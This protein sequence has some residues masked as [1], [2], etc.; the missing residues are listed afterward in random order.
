MFFLAAALLACPAFAQRTTNP[1][2]TTGAIGN[3]GTLVV[4]VR[5]QNGNIPSGLTLVN[6]YSF[7]GDLV[8]SA[9]MQGTQA[10]FQGIGTGRFS[11]EAIAPGYKTNRVDV[12]VDFIGS[13]VTVEIALKPEVDPNAPSAAPAAPLL[14]PRAQKELNKA[15]EDL[16]DGKLK[17]AQRHLDA[18][19]HM[20]PG[21]PD[22]NYLLGVLASM[23]GKRD[24][25]V[26]LWQ[27][28]IDIYPQHTFALL[29]LG[30]AAEEK[31]DLTAAS[32]FFK[33][34]ADSN[35]SSWRSQFSLAGIAYREEKY[36]DAVKYSE[37]ALRIGKDKANEARF[38]QARALALL[39]HRD[40]AVAALQAY[41][42]QASEKPKFA[43][44][45]S[46]ILAELQ[47]AASE[48]PRRSAP[49]KTTTPPA[50][51]AAVPVALL[52]NPSEWLPPDVDAAVPPTT[53]DVACP[54]GDVL[55]GAGKRM[56]EFLHA[57]DRFTATEHLHHED[58]GESGLPSG[59]ADRT[60]Y[61][62]VSI[63]EVRPR[64][65]NVE[66]YR[67]GSLSSE[68]F[69]NHIATRGF[70]SL[71]LVF[72]PYYRDNYEITCEGL[73]TWHGRL[74]WQVHFRQ[75]PDKPSQMMTFRLNGSAYSV[76]LKGRAWVSTTSYQIFRMELDM[77]LAVPEIRLRAEH[78]VVD[79]GPV[80][81]LNHDVR[82]WLPTSAEIFMDFR[83]RRL[84]RT[85]SFS[86]YLLFSVDDRHNVTKPK[87]EPAAEGSLQ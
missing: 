60:F 85:H 66:E 81:F 6:V 8:A 33:R 77:M 16:R 40:K 13:S 54:L 19:Y 38:I 73:S 76:S 35:P 82:L 86:D 83:G 59:A 34:A 12:S 65:L 27:K 79:Y 21:N 50:K 78:I 71:A 61:Y 44:A 53:N 75:R 67:N 47:A 45:A 30:D 56:A 9:S 4:R 48:T 64:L 20:A 46:R 55:A 32:A 2:P 49:R 70:P 72:H 29:A 14:A 3:R 42:A 1:A 17:D 28:T 22:V 74:A 24:E 26:G 7:R 10:S 69:P 57:V 37:A 5:D 80:Q 58:I 43:D 41:L 11:V 25:A 62:L 15:L 39:G 51:P 68:G 84:H 36:E 87:E 23:S 31:G 18:A 63:Q 52:P